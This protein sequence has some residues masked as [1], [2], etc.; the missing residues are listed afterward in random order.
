MTA[1]HSHH[2]SGHHH[3]HPKPGEADF[4]KAFAVGIALNLVFVVVEA[5]AGFFGNSMALLADAGHNL[6]DVLGLMLAWAAHLLS[7]RPP[8]RRFT[9]GLQGSSILAALGN[10][11]LLMVA[12]GAIAWEAIRRMA[13]PPEV[14]GVTMIIVAGIGILINAATAL[15]FARGRKG[16]L[17]I[18]GAFLHMIADAVVSAGVVVAGV[19]VLL[20]GLEWIDPVTSLV[21]VAVIIVGTWSLFRDSLGLALNAV[22]AEID[23]EAVTG[24]LARLPGV[25]AV[26]HLH[27]WPMSTTANALTAHL[28]MPGGHPGDAFLADAAHLVEHE[29]GI[30]HATLQVELG[31]R[32]PDEDCAP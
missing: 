31:E 10:A 20:T 9:Y 26:H 29:F 7:K 18:R 22:P 25:S 12:C 15:L 27:I 23:P 28:V 3:H 6:S 32:C 13:E 17:N 24:R 4:G 16:D 11:I 30:G 14:M 1:A 8:T 5:A 21:I 19:L 2:H